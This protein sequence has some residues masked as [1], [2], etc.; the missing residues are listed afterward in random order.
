MLLGKR[1]RCSMTTMT[2]LPAR[3]SGACVIGML[4]ILG[5]GRVLAL[6]I[7]GVLPTSIGLPEVNVILR[8]SAGAA[9]YS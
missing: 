4:C 6:E 9:P 5:A 2:T 7:P 1:G 8:P 3:Q